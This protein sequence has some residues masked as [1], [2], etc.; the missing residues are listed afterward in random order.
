MAQR[1]VALPLIGL[2]FLCLLLGIWSGLVRV[3][4]PW[5]SLTADFW[6]AHGPL[7]VSGFLGT[8]IALERAVALGKAWGY[9]A[10]ALTA[11]GAL[12]VVADASGWIGPILIL[13]GSFAL[14]A[15]FGII[16][17]R[18]PNPA[19]ATMLLAAVA[20]VLGNLAWVAAYPSLAVYPVVL[21]WMAFLV[22]VIAG[23]RLELSRILRIPRGATAA[24]LVLGDFL[25][26]GAAWVWFG[27]WGGNVLAGASL[28]GLA[29]WLLRYDVARIQ[30]RQRGLSRFIAAALLLGYVWL[31]T[32]G[33]FVLLA[34]VAPIALGYDAML[35]AVFLGFVMS[36]VFA[37]APLI[38]PGILGVDL[39]Y[40]RWFYAHLL[41]LHVGLSL[42]IAGDALTW[43][44]LR[45]WGAL[46]NGVA[47][48]WFLAAT[49]LAVSIGRRER[50]SAM[51]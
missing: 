46:L 6:W 51:A 43:Q 2:A 32:G 25:V 7:M 18:Q 26:V 40:R 4:W 13:F 31:G 22:L 38:F 36:M 30:V 50:Q 28:L 33:V 49:G 34:G 37:H 16:L 12:V 35:H 5:P 1:R 42:R 11:A 17:R 21:W 20:W 19:T 44:S 47:L 9:A 45:E 27:L 39:P 41:L 24:F 10:P 23:E 3:G 15:L 8:L 14:A 48:L 29:A